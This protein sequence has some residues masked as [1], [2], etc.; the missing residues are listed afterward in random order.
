MNHTHGDHN[1]LLG[2]RLTINGY[3]HIAN[4]TI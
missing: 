1:E 2:H 4:Q 3:R